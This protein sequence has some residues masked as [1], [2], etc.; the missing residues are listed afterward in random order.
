VKALDVKLFR[1]LARMKA[2]AIAIALVIASGV[3]LFVAAMTTYR[4]LRVSEH[5]Y[6]ASQRFADVWS[7]LAR[8]PR[9][10]AR[11]LA[12]IPGVAAVDARVVEHAILDVRGLDEPASALVIGIPPGAGHDVDDLYLRRGRHVEPGRAD[13]VL[14]NE[15]FAERNR[16]GP[17]DTLTAVV[18]GRRVALQIVG[19]A[20]SPEYVMAVP[21]GGQ[22]PDDRRFAVV[23]MAEDQLEALA[24]LRDAFD[25]VAVKLVAGADERT[26]IAAID[27][28]LA[29]YGGHGAYGRT[30]NPSHMMLEEHVRQI[31]ALAV[32]VPSIFLLVAA[33]L[34]NVVMSRLIATQREQIGMLKAF[35]Y[36]SG[37]IA[38]HYLELTLL[39]VVAGIAIG[40]PV[41][42][43]L[44]LLMARFYAGFFR[45][46]VLVF[47][48]EPAIVLAA[49]LV[50]IL[51]ATSGVIG[52]LRRVVAMPPIVAMS[53]EV[54][55]FGRGVLDRLGVSAMVTPATRM[56]LRNLSRR[57]VRSTLTLAGMALALA[58][59]VLGDSSADGI[60][61][62]R[63]VRYQGQQ[64]ADATV[65]L[66]H[67][68][69]AG[70]WGD[71]RALPG[72]V[73]AE[74]FRAVPARVRVGDS[75]QDLV[76]YGLRPDARLRRI[77]DNDFH[78]QPAPRGGAIVTT[79]LARRMGLHRGDPISFD[80][81]EGRRRIVT[82]RIAGT[83]DEPLG[84]AA[85]LDLDT[86]DRLLGEPDTFS[87]LDLATD[88]TRSHELY[89]ALKRLPQAVGIDFRVGALA[90]YREMSDTSLRFI[91]R[92]VL[93][94]SL[95]IAFG[96]VY[97]SARIALAE[98]G[99]ELATL[100]VLGFT[101][102][103]ISKVLLGE[104]GL[105]A[106]PAIPLGL[107]LG[108]GLTGRVA[109]A[110]T[111]ERM[112]VPWLLSP[113][114]YAFAVIVFFIEAAIAALVVRRRLDRLD[115]VEVLKARE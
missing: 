40:I 13:E 62:M 93:V 88:P 66:A 103:E 84:V 2:Q 12:A 38:L 21:P 57:P 85:Y 50:A 77:V 32:L 23:W 111:S 14:V 45:F 6:Y 105:L 70:A 55:S 97:N 47:S 78:E 49:S 43:W 33:F 74:P 68:R 46:P 90:S 72:V 87:G 51:A 20:L 25:D 94:F 110:M 59:V 91:R 56:I 112:H 60:N 82:T 58:V 76:L 22:T 107:V 39:I 106:L 26:V 101:R 61:R 54:P 18:S 42:A 80:I 44:G 65:T 115:L 28:V 34:V 7:S 95:I 30:S 35:G 11:K 75:D 114:T 113:G 31:G 67:P 104:I 92:L 64:R 48:V 29:P 1:D 41:G 52:T 109:S 86:L 100:R 81:R 8:A 89:A 69:A 24:D 27:R 19:I 99:R 16:L 5:H 83:V 96:V 108:W 36:G 79:W 102:G 10:V 71:A 15:Q 37:R 63:D 98:R 17:G 9:P 4:S 3:A 73:R 53:P